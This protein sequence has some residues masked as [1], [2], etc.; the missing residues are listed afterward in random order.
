MDMEA[1]FKVQCMNEAIYSK[2][3]LLHISQIRNS[4][5]KIKYIFSLTDLQVKSPEAKLA[6]NL[7][8]K[9]HKKKNSVFWNSM[10]AFELPMD[11]KGKTQTSILD[12]FVHVFQTSER[13]II[14]RSRY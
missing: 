3:D 11:S 6:G 5:F 8:E 12:Q 2:T 13:C 9:L 14:N 1:I 4:L 7:S 10:G